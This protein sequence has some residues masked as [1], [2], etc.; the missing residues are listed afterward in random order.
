MSHSQIV[1]MLTIDLPVSAAVEHFD[2]FR[3]ITL[4]AQTLVQAQSPQEM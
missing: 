2:G 4:V 1:N 3:T